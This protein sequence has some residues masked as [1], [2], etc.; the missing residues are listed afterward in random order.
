MRADCHCDTALLLHE[1]GSL[2]H[3]PEAHQDWQRISRC[4]D[5]S[6]FAVFA[7]QDKH[8][9]DGGDIFRQTAYLLRQ[10]M[11]SCG[12][13][14]EFLTCKEQLAED[15]DTVKILLALEGA[16]PL[17]SG[18]EYLDDFFRMGLRCVGLTWNQKNAY[19]GGCKSSGVLTDDGRKLIRRCEA[20]GVLVDCAHANADSLYQ[21]LEYA[22]KPFIVSHA[23]C[24]ALQPHIRNLDDEQ[25]RM[26][27]E[28]DCVMGI[29]FVPEFLG[30]AG[31][32]DMICRHI[33]HAA[34]IMGSR[35]VAIGSDFDGCCPHGEMASVECIPY[36][37]KRLA[38]LGL[39][40]EDIENIMGESVK[41]LLAAV[42]PC[43]S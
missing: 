14:L 9:S 31:D 38:E 5:L 12:L 2:L 10:D 26:L 13:P 28:H 8:F 32:M 40:D 20:L 24:A 30:G 19:A 3:L 34:E 27:A 37:G 1:H 22:R 43:R 33:I 21:T 7:D 6:F 15:K 36:I 39:S 42:L 18:G 4:L 29:A 23:C 16:A 41:R 25:M 35:H 11:E 17:G